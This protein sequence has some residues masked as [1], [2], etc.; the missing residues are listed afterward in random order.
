[1]ALLL[2][3]HVVLFMHIHIA[4]RCMTAFKLRFSAAQRNEHERHLE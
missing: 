1:V 2:W 3:L 4:D